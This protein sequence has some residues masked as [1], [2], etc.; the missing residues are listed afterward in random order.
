VAALLGAGV[1]LH[2]LRDPTRGGVAATCNE[3]AVAADVGL[4]LVDSAVPVPEAVAT[5][6]E[7]L[8]LDPLEVANEGRLVAFVGAADAERAV[9]V[10]ESHPLGAGAARI[11]SVTEAHAGLVVARTGIGGSRVVDLPLAEQL[12]RIC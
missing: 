5:A 2:L 8:G 11:G 3:V 4:E 1:D 10:M 6:C 12:P 9:E 7:L